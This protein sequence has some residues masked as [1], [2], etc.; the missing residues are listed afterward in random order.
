MGALAAWM[1]AA[2]AAQAALLRA[3]AAGDPGRELS[4]RRRV[5]PLLAVEHLGLAI[6]L[7]AG[8]ALLE[9][10]GWGFG[11]ARWLGLKL[12]LTLFLVLPLEGMHAWVCHA[13][14]ARGLRQTPTPPFSRDLERAIGMDDMIRALAA[15]LLGVGIPLIVWLSVRKPF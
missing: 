3:R 9:T 4:M 13:W 11:R 2:L 15:P 6:A 8:F 5:Q 12:G 7:A 14:I 1:G 10:R